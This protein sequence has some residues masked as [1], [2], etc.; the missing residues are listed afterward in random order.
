MPTRTLMVLSVV[1]RSAKRD[2][3]LLNLVPGSPVTMTRRSVGVPSPGSVQTVKAGRTYVIFG[4][5]TDGA[6]TGVNL[7]GT[8]ADDDLAGTQRADRINGLQ[9]DDTIHGRKGNDTLR[10]EGDDDRDCRVIR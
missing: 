6:P 9:G 8:D 1:L 4:R 5:D 10:G 2:S 3:V 7:R